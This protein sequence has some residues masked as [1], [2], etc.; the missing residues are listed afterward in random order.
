MCR[1]DLEHSVEMVDSEALAREWPAP[2]IASMQILL[3][4]APSNQ[5]RRPLWLRREAREA[6]G[7]VR[8]S[9]RAR[10]RDRARQSETAEREQRE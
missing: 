10:E 8:R 9:E 3:G 7:D 5:R 2:A 4:S 1:T 6:R